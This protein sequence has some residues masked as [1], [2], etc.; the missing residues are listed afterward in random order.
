QFIIN[1]N[2]FQLA[3]VPNYADDVAADSDSNLPSGG[4]YTVTG[5]RSLRIKP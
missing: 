4:I 2:G 5:D 1:D 3:G